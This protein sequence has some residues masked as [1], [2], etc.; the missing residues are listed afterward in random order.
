[1]GKIIS[2]LIRNCILTSRPASR[3]GPTKPSLDHHHQ[4]QESTQQSAKASESHSSETTTIEN[5]KADVKK[6]ESAQ[7][8]TDDVQTVQPTRQSESAQTKKS[9]NSGICDS[10]QSAANGNVNRGD[11][12]SSPSPR[13]SSLY[14]GTGG[15]TLK[16]GRA[17]VV[18]AAHA[19][20]TTRHAFGATVKVTK[21]D[22]PATASIAKKS[23][24][25]V[26]GTGG[27]VL[28]TDSATI[29]GSSKKASKSPR[30]PRQPSVSPAAVKAASSSSS[31]SL[32]SYPSTTRRTKAPPASPPRAATQSYKRS[33]AKS[34][35]M[36]PLS[37][38][39]S[40]TRSSPRRPD[41]LSPGLNG[42]LSRSGNLCVPGSWETQFFA[43]SNLL[44]DLKNEL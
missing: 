44:R 14:Y 42:T 37:A 7:H 29:A 9:A 18:T 19:Q 4:A 21:E 26:E 38:S 24:R 1:M 33:Q 20:K 39:P 30:L 6:D 16:A 34:P 25:L 15:R 36:T 27:A 12:R 3:N 35:G 32:G 28:S 5:G 22:K 40:R 11:K 17:S 13:S 43:D 23:V 2:N 8:I 31:S 41:S 10:S